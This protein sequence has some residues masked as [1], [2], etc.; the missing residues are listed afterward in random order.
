[1]KEITSIILNLSFTA[2]AIYG[3]D[4]LS[5]WKKAAEKLSKMCDE[6]EK[7]VGEENVS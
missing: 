6:M 1:M 5:K 4:V 2:F 3:I 7:L